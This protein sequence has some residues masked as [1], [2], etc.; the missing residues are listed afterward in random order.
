MNDLKKHLALLFATALLA[1][2][3]G[4]SSNQASLVDVAQAAARASDRVSVEDLASWLIE[5]RQDFVL[6]DIRPATEFG[7]GHI[8]EARNISIAQLLTDEA[9]AELPT[10]R[11]VIVYSTGSENGAKASTLL[12]V[13]GV[14]AHVVT[15]GYNAWHQRILNPDISADELDGESPVVSAQRA[16]SCYFVGDRGAGSPERPEVEFVPPVFTEEEL[17]EMEPLPPAGQESC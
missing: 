2:C 12:R 15:G 14:D 17:E 10:D 5:G 16:Y 6:I 1:A 11:K 4:S 7:K 8:G 9:L 13:A 3:G